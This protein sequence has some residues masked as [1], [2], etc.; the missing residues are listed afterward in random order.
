[1][2][3]GAAIAGGL[4]FVGG[5]MQ[6][7]ANKKAATREMQ[8]QEHMSNTA[9]QR[10]VADLRAAGLNPVLSANGGASTPSGASYQA[11]NVLAPAVNSAMAARR[12]KED[13]KNSVQQREV[14]QTQDGLNVAAQITQSSQD[15]LNK[16][17]AIKALED[18]KLSANNARTSAANAR[19]TEAMLPA[20]LSKESLE[21]TEF[22]RMLRYSDRVFESLG[23]AFGSSAKSNFR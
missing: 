10:E 8:F 4:G 13:I 23:K 22:G 14:M 1:M 15:K 18:A 21:N 16:A 3:W 17:L 20:S 9:H 6:N 7:T 5:I 11:E 19:L 2:S 12:L